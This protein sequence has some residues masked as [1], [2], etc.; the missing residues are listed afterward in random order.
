MNASESV[1][2]IGT[3]PN[4]SRISGLFSGTEGPGDGG[5]LTLTTG[6]LIIKDGSAIAVSSQARKNAI[7]DDAVSK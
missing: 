4:G 7:Y 2:L 1:E 3:S 5:N 6:R